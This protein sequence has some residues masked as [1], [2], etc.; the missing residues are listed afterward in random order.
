MNRKEQVFKLKEEA[1]KKYG[2]KCFVCGRKFGK[3]FTFH[4]KYY[5]EGEKYYKDFA[6][7]EDYNEYIVKI[8]KRN[9][10]QF[11]LLCYRHHFTVEMF[12]KYKKETLKKLLS[13]VKMSK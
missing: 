8:V 13:A 9:P 6:N 5:V 10:K 2:S 3:G 7:G 11:L 4:H 1:A 12:K